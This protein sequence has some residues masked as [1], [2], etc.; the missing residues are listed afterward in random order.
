MKNPEILRTAATTL[1]ERGDGPAYALACA[2]DREANKTRLMEWDDV[3]D[4]KMMT[5]HPNG[6]GFDKRALAQ[7][8]TAAGV[9]ELD[10]TNAASLVITAWEIL[11]CPRD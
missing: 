3:I 4:D 7:T 6:Y 5:N 11:G 2:F 8:E 9:K 10:S 1:R